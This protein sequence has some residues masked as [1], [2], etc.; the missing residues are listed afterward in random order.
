MSVGL[1]IL[2]ANGTGRWDACS[3][4]SINKLWALR[5]IIQ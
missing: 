3:D 4:R 5:K 2:A 1:R